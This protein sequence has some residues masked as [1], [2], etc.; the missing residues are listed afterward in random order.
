VLRLL[1]NLPLKSKLLITTFVL[2]VA[3]V[4][5]TCAL[6]VASYLQDSKSRV[7]SEAGNQARLVVHDALSALE[8]RDKAAAHMILQVLRL[9][10]SVQGARLFDDRGEILAEYRGKAWRDVTLPHTAPPAD[11]DR[12]DELYLE[13]TRVVKIDK[14]T[15]GTLVVATDLLPFRYELTGFTVKIGLIAMVALL[16]AFSGVVLMHTRIL[17]PVSALAALVRRSVAEKRFELRATTQP[18]DEVGTLAADVN[19]LLERIG[20]RE[21]TL[22]RE[23]MERSETQRRIEELAHFD[24]L[25]KLPNRHYFVRQL[26]RTLLASLQSGSAGAVLLV[27]L[28]AFRQVNDRFGHDAGD[29]LLLQFGRRVTA[30]LREG[31]MLCR[32]GGDDFALILQQ[33]SGESHV[34]A[35]ANKILSVVKE[36]IPVGEH[37]AQVGVSIG[38]AVFP[39]DGSEPHLV[40]RNAETALRRAKSAGN[41]SV[42]FFAPEMLDR[43]HPQLNIE[44]ELRRALDE[45]ELRLHFQPQMDLATGALRGMEGLVRWQHPVRG[46]LLPGEFIPM[47]EDNHALIRAIS[48]WTLDATCAQLAAWQTAGLDPVTLAVNFTPVQLRDTGMVARLDELLERYGVPGAG[49]E[50]EITEN[51]LMAEPR[52]A[53]ILGE[54]RSRGLRIAVDDFGTGYSSLAYLKDLPITALKIDRGFVHGVPDSPKYASI[55]RAIIGIARHLGFETIAEG[56]ETPRQA[57]FLRALGCTAYQGFCFSAAVPADEAERFLASPN[58]HSLDRAVA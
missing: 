41:N 45:S 24:P 11:A 56:V 5:L 49:M 20:E 22:R 16:I 15:A 7:I 14:R 38:I 17:N 12:F 39:V 27:N 18:H 21:A 40:L 31:D 8:S 23:L 48:D 28:A 35:V 19:A 6:A 51:L 46:L 52:A 32:L 25:T 54:L 3:A 55:T 47:A 36:P 44:A 33:V 43:L 42:C 4:A 2:L 57:E 1:A 9:N 10:A 26:E 53:E 29:T 13:T 34:T 50:L 37:Q 30:K 58:R